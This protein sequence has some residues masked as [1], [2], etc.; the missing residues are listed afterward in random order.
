M[1][2][3]ISMREYDYKKIYTKLLTL[4]L[5]YRAGYHV[6]KNISIEKLIERTKGTYCMNCRKVLQTGTK[7]KTTAFPS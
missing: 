2:W 5:L 3:G 4:L 1:L 6:G 7:R